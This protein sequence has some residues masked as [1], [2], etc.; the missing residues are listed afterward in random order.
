M[1]PGDGQGAENGGVRKPSMP[2]LSADVLNCAEHRRDGDENGYPG[3][4]RLLV[5]HGPEVVKKSET[6][7][8]PPPKLV[9]WCGVSVTRPTPPNKFGGGTQ[10]RR[11]IF[12]VVGEAHVSV[13][14][15]SFAAAR[16]ETTEKD[17][18]TEGVGI[19]LCRFWE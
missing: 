4:Q 10:R 13:F 9:W 19:R 1:V 2:I 8:V 6:T 17:C 15:R 3:K 7:W 5:T 14:L 11:V 12:L 16:N 18:P